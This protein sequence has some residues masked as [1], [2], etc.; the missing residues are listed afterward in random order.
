MMTT[1]REPQSSGTEGHG[2]LGQR[3]KV[4][5]APAGA[6]VS[7]PGSLRPLTSG[8]VKGTLSWVPM[9]GEG[10]G[11]ADVGS[12]GSRPWEWQKL[13]HHHWRRAG[14]KGPA[15]LRELPAGQRVCPGH[16]QASMLASGNTGTPACSQGCWRA[17]GRC[18]PT[19]QAGQVPTQQR[20]ITSRREG[21]RLKPGPSPH[22]EHCPD[23]EQFLLSR[24]NLLVILPLCSFGVAHAPPGSASP[25]HVSPSLLVS[26]TLIGH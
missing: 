7:P 18:S 10:E 12:S 2:D 15:Q 26:E 3:A 17:W 16:S 11:S 14:A 23:S 25:A 24:R 1:Q 21:V 5:P 4:A 22:P 6:E 9:P 13:G 8:I 20:T 19:T